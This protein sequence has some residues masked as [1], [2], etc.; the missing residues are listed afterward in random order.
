MKVMLQIFR[1]WDVRLALPAAMVSLVGDA[2]AMVALTLRVHDTG[3][4][5]YA[6]ALLLVCFS[7]PVVVTM[8]LVGHVA[9]TVDPRLVLGAGGLVQMLACLGLARW[10][11]LAAT[12]ALVVVLQTGFAFANPVWSSVLTRAVGDHHV[13]RLVSTQQAL[14]AVAAPVGAALGGVLVELRGDAVVFLL[15]AATYAV[16]CGAGLAVR[17]RVAGIVNPTED[18]V[19]GDGVTASGAVRRTV[20]FLPRAGLA[21]VRAD[22]VVWVLVCAMLPFVVSLESMNAVEVFLARDELHASQAQFGYWQALTGVGAV[23]G[24]VAAG[25]LRA[26][27]A[28]LRAL[29][30]ALA[31]MSLAQVGSGVAASLVWLYAF[32]AVL[33]LANA[34]SN[35]ALF[36]VFMRR[37]APGDRGKA[38]AVVNGLARTCT[39]LA[40]GL[41]GLGAS[42]IGP[43]GSF[44]VAGCCGVA[45]ACWAGWS[46]HRIGALRAPNAAAAVQ[47]G[48][49][50]VLELPDIPKLH[51]HQER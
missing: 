42:T 18:G 12:Y 33:G 29:V 41:G 25:V 32:G 23:V 2:M 40:L 3:A 20:A 4:G 35:A 28:R 30:V 34:V 47:A 27:T 22:R 44:V 43:R 36:A 51:F 10:N 48:T 45:V 14:G 17:T 39:M 46:L 5:P 6:V 38:L 49:E 21:V 37:T 11:G 24:A 13:G 8:G 9:D 1:I 7:L 31:V 26:D 16:L 19:A 15:D 50:S